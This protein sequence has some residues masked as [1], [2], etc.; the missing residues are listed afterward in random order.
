MKDQVVLDS[1]NVGDVFLFK[2]RRYKFFGRI[3]RYGEDQIIAYD[4]QRVMNKERYVP[5]ETFSPAERVTIPRW[6]RIWNW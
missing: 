4:I 5:Y 2:R 3:N 1:L 6:G